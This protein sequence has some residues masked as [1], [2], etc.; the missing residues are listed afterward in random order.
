M[1][2]KTFWMSKLL[3]WNTGNTETS[4]ERKNNNCLPGVFTNYRGSYP[5]ILE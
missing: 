5:E 4:K 3:K 2:A 1:S